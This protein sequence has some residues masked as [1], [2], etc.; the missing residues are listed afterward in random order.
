LANEIAHTLPSI[1]FQKILGSGDEMFFT[2]KMNVFISSS[3]PSVYYFIFLESRYFSGKGSTSEK[4]PSIFYTEN[5]RK[6]GVI[7]LKGTN[8]RTEK[9]VA[10]E[11]SSQ[12]KRL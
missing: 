4:V 10:P 6:C 1:F 11:G 12:W 9:Y 2:S 8:G 7:L 5:S 3:S